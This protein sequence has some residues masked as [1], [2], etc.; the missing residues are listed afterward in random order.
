MLSTLNKALGLVDGVEEL[1]V[2]HGQHLGIPVSFT[3][4]E[5]LPCLPDLDARERAQ[6]RATED[7]LRTAYQALQAIPAPIEERMP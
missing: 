3:S 4:G 5:P 7:H 1:A 6:L 2:P